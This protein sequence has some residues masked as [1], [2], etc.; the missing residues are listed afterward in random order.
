MR[1]EVFGR[2]R[3]PHLIWWVC[4]VDIYAVLGGTGNGEFIDSI[5]KNDF[6]PLPTEQLWP[7]P[8]PGSNLVFPEE[9]DFLP[10]VLIFNQKIAVLA[11]QLGQLARELL[12]EASRH[13]Y[14]ASTTAHLDFMDRQN[15]VFETQDTFRRTWAREVPDFISN[16]R[17][18]PPRVQGVFDQA[19]AL[20]RTCI[21][22]SHT[23]MWPTQRVDMGPGAE[24]EIAQC[25]SEVL[26]L[27]NSIIGSHRLEQ[28]F[29]V[30]PL[31]MAGFSSSSGEEKM[32][33]LDLM[34]AMEQE[35]IGR[36]T[37]ATRQLLQLVYERQNES[38]M[39]TGHSL[40]V[41]W[42]DTM[43]ESGLQ[44]VNCGL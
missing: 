38:L 31:F 39:R 41:D 22:Y 40:H 32:L 33:A 44:V 5:L 37:R 27:A 16:A 24:D 42:I 34:S 6:L 29:I 19:H 23:S 17:S 8:P 43:M 1:R 28:R 30:F 14:T 2:E 9:H 11:S 20:Y 13:M 26:H 25:V 12:S 15:R 36:N 7:R 21:L 35:S 10:P 3:Y 4:L 18:L